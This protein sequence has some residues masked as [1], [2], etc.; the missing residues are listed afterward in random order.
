MLVGRLPCEARP[1]WVLF[2]FDYL[3]P[4]WSGWESSCSVVV[5]HKFGLSFQLVHIVDRFDWWW[6][7]WEEICWALIAED[8]VAVFI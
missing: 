3:E 7:I 2:V 1:G 8:C 4:P 5:S 6:P